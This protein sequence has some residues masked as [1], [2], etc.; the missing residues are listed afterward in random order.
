M[1]RVYARVLCVGAWDPA[2]CSE[3]T[4]FSE[5]QD[6]WCSCLGIPATDPDHWLV[7]VC[8]AKNQNI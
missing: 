3:R 1:M 6:C 4:D 2:V 5:Y 7:G 8:A